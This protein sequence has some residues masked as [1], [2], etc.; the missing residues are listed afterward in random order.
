MNNSYLVIKLPLVTLRA[1]I[2]VSALL[3]LCSC[4]GLGNAIQ[5]GAEQGSYMKMGWMK[6]DPNE[7][8]PKTGFKRLQ[9]EMTYCRAVKKHVV[10]EGMPDYLSVPADNRLYL[11]YLGRG[12]IYEF[13]THPS[14]VLQ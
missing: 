8:A 1:A 2:V 12:F 4:S 10:E 9:N 3:L 5:L 13:D 11:A 6:I 14:V 7:D